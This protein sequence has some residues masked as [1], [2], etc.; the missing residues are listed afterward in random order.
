MPKISPDP[1]SARPKF[2]PQGGWRTD[3]S[4][5]DEV[6]NQGPLT[7][8]MYDLRKQ[9]REGG[10]SPAD[11]VHRLDSMGFPNLIR[12]RDQWLDI[13]SFYGWN[14]AFAATHAEGSLKLAAKHAAVVSDGVRPGT[15][16]DAHE[17]AERILARCGG[18]TRKAGY[19]CLLLAGAIVGRGGSVDEAVRIVA[20][21][22]ESD[23]LTA[24]QPGATVSENM[25]VA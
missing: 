7:R 17:L 23:A 8:L 13:E 16:A 15:A 10:L 25:E 2:P 24:T 12:N 22:L 11:C 6:D 18:A 4:W 1:V 14:L 21:K 5:G 3:G 20:S 9:I 19:D